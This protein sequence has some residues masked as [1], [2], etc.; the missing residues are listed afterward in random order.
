MTGVQLSL[1]ASAWI[2]YW[3]SREDS[4]ERKSLDWAIERERELVRGWPAAVLKAAV[5]LGI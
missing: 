1:L 5:D 2:A 3:R 4:L